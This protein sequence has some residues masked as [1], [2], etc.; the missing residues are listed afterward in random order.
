[1]ESP[2]VIPRATPRPQDPHKW[3]RSLHRPHKSTL[4]TLHMLDRVSN[5]TPA[6]AEPTLLVAVTTCCGH[7]S[8][9]NGRRS[10]FHAAE[11]RTLPCMR[12]PTSRSPISS[13]P[14]SRFPTPVGPAAVAGSTSSSSSAFASL[15]LINAFAS[16]VMLTSRHA[17]PLSA[18]AISE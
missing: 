12:S 9:G 15:H 5:S 8:R 3:F 11:A 7:R 10:S 1:M 2:A 13:F 16:S 4:C 6:V 17:P 18:T 14:T